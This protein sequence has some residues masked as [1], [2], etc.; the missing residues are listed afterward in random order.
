MIDI[1][2]GFSIAHRLERAEGD[3]GTQGRREATQQGTEREQPQP[4]LEHPAPAEPVGHRTREHQQ[5]GDDQRVGVDHPLQAT[6]RCVQRLLDRG[7]RHIGDRRVKPRHDHA[8][9]AGQQ[10]DGPPTRRQRSLD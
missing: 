10:H 2:T 4:D 9:A 1:A 8:Q 6:D 3:Q 7:Q 5:A